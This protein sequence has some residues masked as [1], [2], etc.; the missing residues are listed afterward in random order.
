M[1]DY[2]SEIDWTSLQAIGKD[3]SGLNSTDDI[4]EIDSILE[5]TSFGDSLESLYL[6][7]EE[8]NETQTFLVFKNYISNVP[9]SVSINNSNFKTGILWDTS[10]D[11]NTEYD[12]TEKEDIIF[13]TNTNINTAGTYGVT[14][15]E[16]RV[17]AKLREYNT[18]DQTTAAFY[19]EIN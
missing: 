10:D 15:Y 9:V 19:I 16:L 18:T 14:D 17:P 12:S 7:G 11:T 4:I 5:M 1:T 2:D 13:I 8:I 3:T 6:N